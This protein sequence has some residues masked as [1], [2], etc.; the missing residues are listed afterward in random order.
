VIGQWI[1]LQ[2]AF[3]PQAFENAFNF[4]QSGACNRMLGPIVIAGLST[5]ALS[6][7]GAVPKY[8]R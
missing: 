4:L 5:F 8:E 3:N 7:T 6:N 2:L 1:L